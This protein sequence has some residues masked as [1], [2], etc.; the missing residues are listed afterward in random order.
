MV[1]RREQIAD[2]FSTV[3]QKHKRAKIASGESMI[4]KWE[5]VG[6]NED[7]DDYRYFVPS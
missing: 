4:G 5:D 6:G 2:D 7:K 1:V 3:R